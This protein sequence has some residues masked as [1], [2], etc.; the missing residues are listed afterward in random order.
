ME[1]LICLKYGFPISVFDGL[2]LG[3]VAFTIFGLDV[4]WYGIFIGAAII[5]GTYLAM[6]YMKKIGGNPD[7]IL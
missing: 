6:R 1:V 2:N 5:L 7:D 3:R 4:Y